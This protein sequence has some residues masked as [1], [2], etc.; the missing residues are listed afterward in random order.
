MGSHTLRRVVH[1][2]RS[3]L[4]YIRLGLSGIRNRD[5]R[6]VHGRPCL[7]IGIEVL[8]EDFLIRIIQASLHAVR[9][10]FPKIPIDKSNATIFETALDIYC[11]SFFICSFVLF[12]SSAF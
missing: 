4:W 1:G 11:P 9:G 5:A 6:D 3:T 7:S 2:R 12:L 8:F 10:E